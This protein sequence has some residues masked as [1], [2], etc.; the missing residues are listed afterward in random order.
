MPYTRRD[1]RKERKYRKW[2]WSQVSHVL[3]PNFVKSKF[4][5]AKVQSAVF[6]V[7][8]MQISWLPVASVTSWRETCLELRCPGY[9][10]QTSKKEGCCSLPQHRLGVPAPCDM[11]WTSP[12]GPTFAAQCGGVRAGLQGREEPERRRLAGEVACTRRAAR[13]DRPAGKQLVV[14]GPACCS[15]QESGAALHR[16]SGGR[17]GRVFPRP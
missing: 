17:R 12:G 3:S 1:N 11:V 4:L 2:Y 8:N 5:M 7:L 10:P 16:L 14:G 6:R 15:P 13:H 9:Q